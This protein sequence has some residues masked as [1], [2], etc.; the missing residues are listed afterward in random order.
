MKIIFCLPGNRFSGNFLSCWSE[1]LLNCISKGIQPLLSQ[2]YSCNIY[3]ARTM[4]IGGDVTRGESQSPFGGQ[5]DYDYIMWIDSD[6]IFNSEQFFKLLDHKKDICS[7][8]Y[9]MEGGQR[10][11]CVKDWD[12]EFFAKHGHFNFL[13]PKDTE[14]DKDLFEVNYAGMGWML[15]KKGVFESIQYPWFEP[16]RKKIGEYT[17]FTMEDV[18]FCH[19]AIQNNYLIHIDPTIVVGHEKTVIL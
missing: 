1:L 5:V 14:N 18:A 17:D 13:S 15:V 9:L 3:Y 2:R 10:Y 19:K 4:C 8:L 7:G 16:I 12:E 11:A 6:I